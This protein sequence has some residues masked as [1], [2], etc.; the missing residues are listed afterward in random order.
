MYKYKIVL[1]GQGGYFFCS[2]IDN[3]IID[4]WL[5]KKSF[6][7]LQ[8]YVL[9]QYMQ[10][11]D[12]DDEWRI[13]ENFRF[14][15]FNNINGLCLWESDSIEINTSTICDLYE[16]NNS[17]DNFET[18]G[19]FTAHKLIDSFLC[20]DNFLI[21]KKENSWSFLVENEFKKKGLDKAYLIYFKANARG[22]AT[23][24][25]ILQDEDKIDKK[26]LKFYTGLLGSGEFMSN[27]VKKALYKPDCPEEKVLYDFHM[28]KGAR[29]KPDFDFTGIQEI[30]ITNSKFNMQWLK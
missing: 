6:E 19:D 4:F 15:I 29:E 10:D 3:K 13:P 24:D 30:S 26:N 25:D 9:A 14:D 18:E 28:L 23:H 7:L 5:N 20:T 1:N 21:N 27:V 11:H 17:D 2:M 8:E 12:I 22:Y 16:I